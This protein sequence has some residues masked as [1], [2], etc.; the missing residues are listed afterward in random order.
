MELWI[1]LF[2]QHSTV[3]EG[4]RIKVFLDFYEVQTLFSHLQNSKSRISGLYS[5]SLY[6]VFIE[7]TP[8]K[9]VFSG[10]SDFPVVWISF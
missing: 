6:F 3:P 10:F 4:K 1:I 8:L 2:T 5:W 9:Q 7:A